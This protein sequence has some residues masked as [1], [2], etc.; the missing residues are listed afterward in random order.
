M[1]GAD[2]LVERKCQ[3]DVSY[4]HELVVLAETGEKRLEKGN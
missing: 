3:N 1:D 4:H 2:Y